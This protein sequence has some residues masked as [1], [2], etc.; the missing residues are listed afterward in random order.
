MHT[1]IYNYMYI[2]I[3]KYV[4]TNVFKFVVI[5]IYVYIHIVLKFCKIYVE[6]KDFENRKPPTHIRVF[7]QYIYYKYLLT[8]LNDIPIFTST[9]VYL[10]PSM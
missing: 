3:Y 6:R 8:S 1:L 4:S 10:Y 7:R 9:R 5:C 2:L